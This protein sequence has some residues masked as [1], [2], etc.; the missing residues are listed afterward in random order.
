MSK[1]Q[2]AYIVFLGAAIAIA[3]AALVYSLASGGSA[4]EKVAILTPEQ[5][6]GF[7][8]Y[9]FDPEVSPDGA[10]LE[11][12]VCVPDALPATPIPTQTPAPTATLTPVP[13]TATPVP[14]TATPTLVP[15]TATPLPPTPTPTAVSGVRPFPSSGVIA[16]PGTYSGSRSSTSGD[17]VT[18]R[19][20]NVSIVNSTIGPCNGRGLHLDHVNNFVIRNSIV[21]NNKTGTCCERYT[22]VLVNGG[23]NV[24]IENNEIKRGESLVQV[25]GGASNVV[26]QFNYADSPKGPF[27]RGQF[28]QVQGNSGP[29]AIVNNVYECS[30]AR[31]CYQEDAINIWRGH[32]ILIEGNNI[33]TGGALGRSSGCGIIVEGNYN[34]TIKNNV[35]RNVHLPG[36][37]TVDGC[38]IAVSGGANVLIEGNHVFNYGNIAYYCHD[39]SGA[40]APNGVTFRNNF[41]GTRQDGVYNVFWGG[42]CPGLVNEGFTRE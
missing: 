27:P 19:A 24:L 38:G 26:I 2:L 42:N 7:T 33:D 5:P 35:V 8:C 39:Y 32:D 34:V 22:T 10:T 16:E 15:P 29:V 28:V 31:G 9:K 20:D 23:N 1:T 13:A 11:K 18:V 17:C 6:S 37:A 4:S 21:D 25:I 3:V 14:P 41:A 12:I 40:P 36:S 30:R